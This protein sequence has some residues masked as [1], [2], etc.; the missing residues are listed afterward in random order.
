MR[1]HRHRSRRPK[2]NLHK[3]R[4]NEKIKAPEVRVVDD[5]GT[6]LGILETAK[7]VAIAVAKEMDLVEVSPKAEPPVCKILDFGQFKYQKEK[8][9]RKQKAQSKEIGMKAVRLSVRI[10]DHDFNTR[11]KQASKFLDRGDKVKIELPMRGRE[12]AHKN[13][14]TDVIK[15]FIETLK[16]S[17]E[18]RTEQVVT[19]QGGRMTAIVTKA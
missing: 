2:L 9:A 14:A 7:A 18:L 1:I 8:D 11:I 13:V 6:A 10:G 17:Y 19:Y 15:R 3:F 16:E 4:V 12:K 5:D